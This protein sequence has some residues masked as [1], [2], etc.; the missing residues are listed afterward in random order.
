M[1][2]YQIRSFY[3]LSPTDKAI[4][5]FFHYVKERTEESMVAEETDILT[6]ICLFSSSQISN[7]YAKLV[8]N[9]A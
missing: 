7:I 8:L 4:P 9:K 1:I 2:S 6:P 5:Y 3:Y